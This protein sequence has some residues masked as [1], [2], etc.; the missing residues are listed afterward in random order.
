MVA[1]GGFGSSATAETSLSWHNGLGLER[2]H[3]LYKKEQ[4]RCRVLTLAPISKAMAIAEAAKYPTLTANGFDWYALTGSKHHT[5]QDQQ[6]DREY[7]WSGTGLLQITYA[8]QFSKENRISPDINSYGLK[9]VI[10]RW[11]TTRGDHK[12][13]SNG[14]AILGLSIA[15]YEVIPIDN[16][17]NCLFQWKG[18]Q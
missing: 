13:I 3:R 7:L 14:C 15:G 4:W 1:V 8:I 10:E 12:Y 5:K 9:H 6:E 17:P 11:S 2:G 16:S 18:H